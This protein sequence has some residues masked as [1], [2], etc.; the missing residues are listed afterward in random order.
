M[1]LLSTLFGGGEKVDKKCENCHSIISNVFHSCIVEVKYL[2]FTNNKEVDN[3]DY[4]GQKVFT[5]DGRVIPFTLGINSEQVC[6]TGR[7]MIYRFC[8][9]DCENQIIEKHSMIMNPDIYNKS[10]ILVPSE[11]NYNMLVSIPID[12]L[13]T[14]IEKCEVCNDEYKEFSEPDVVPK[15]QSN[16]R[17][18]TSIP[19]KKFKEEVRE[20]SKKPFDDQI[21]NEYPLILTGLT[22]KKKTKGSYFLY[23]TEMGNVSEHKICS[24]ECGFILSKKLNRIIM[25]VSLIEKNRMGFITPKQNII[26]SDLGNRNHSRPTFIN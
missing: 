8:S 19:I 26:N 13:G 18:W 17:Q 3:V 6:E 20:F 1:G 5:K 21:L 22:E 7:Y 23:K 11:I 12:H 25:T 16:I 9:E 24:S 15:N 2:V 4:E 10:L 14:K